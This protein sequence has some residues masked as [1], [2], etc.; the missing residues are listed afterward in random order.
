MGPTKWRGHG[1]GL[2]AQP[3]GI[4]GVS[5]LDQ[6]L[7]RGQVEIVAD[8]PLDEAHSGGGGA[9]DHT[10]DRRRAGSGIDQV[11]RRTEIDRAGDVDVACA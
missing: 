2:V 3:C 5:G 4:A 9:I 1:G 11:T 8:E 10:A 6:V 7:R